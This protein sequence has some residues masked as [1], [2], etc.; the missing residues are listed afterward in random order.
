MT[1]SP[2]FLWAQL[3]TIDGGNIGSIVKIRPIPDN[4]FLL[5]K[6]VHDLKKTSLKHCDPGNLSTTHEGNTLQLNFPCANISNVTAQ[7][8]LIVVA[9]QGK[10]D[11]E[12]FV[13]MT[14]LV[15][16]MFHTKYTLFEIQ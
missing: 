6:A 4:I 8:P 13:L 3:V 16:W 9:P 14:L 5:Q 12:I 15:S 10:F 2:S 11:L 1:L 7:N